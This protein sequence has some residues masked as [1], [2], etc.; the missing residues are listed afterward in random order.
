MAL[1]YVTSTVVV[2]LIHRDGVASSAGLDVDYVDLST[3]LYE[4]PSKVRV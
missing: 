1:E 3:E 4:L 2:E